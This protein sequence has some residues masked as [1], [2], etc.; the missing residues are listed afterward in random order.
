MHRLLL[1]SS[2]TLCF[3]AVQDGPTATINS[4]GTDINVSFCNRLAIP[5]RWAFLLEWRRGGGGLIHHPG[6]PTRLFS[7][8]TQRATDGGVGSRGASVT[9]W[10]KIQTSSRQRQL[11]IPQPAPASPP[12]D[13]SSLAGLA[14]KLHK[15]TKTTSIDSSAISWRE[16]PI[17]FLQS[18]RCPSL[19]IDNPLTLAF[20]CHA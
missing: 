9:P 11:A 6:S 10:C 17:Y 12:S 1:K 8:R 18:R 15:W 5:S 3:K 19:F 16:E 20:R 13:A 7:A 2:L 14:E 4:A